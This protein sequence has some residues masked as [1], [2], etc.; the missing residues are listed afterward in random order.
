MA[1]RQHDTCDHNQVPVYQL[2]NS[3]TFPPPNLAEPTG[4]LAIGGDLSTE[5]LLQAYARGIFPWY[6][7]GDPLL[8]WSPDPRTILIPS[9]FHCPRRL[10]RTVRQQMFTVRADT[11]FAQVIEACATITREH[12]KGTWIT[13][14]MQTAYIQLHLGGFAHSIETWQDNQLVGGLYGVSL[15]RC[16]FGE[17]MFT[18]ASNASKTALAVMVQKLIDWNFHFIDCQFQTKHLSRFG[19]REISRRKYLRLLEHA[20]EHP[21]KPGPWNFSPNNITLA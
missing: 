9:E 6:S 12:E 20:L 15:G 16:F 17:S 14:E 21:S 8:W 19:A 4:L 10:E 18:R 13:P 2:N 5:R 11:N 7:P 3:L 1:A